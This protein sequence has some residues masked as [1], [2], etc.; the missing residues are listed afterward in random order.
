MNFTHYD[1]GRL[2]KGRTVEVHLQGSVANVYLL[3]QANLKLYRSGMEF[4]AIGGLA[5]SSPVRLQTV[6]AAHWHV[7]ID[8]PNSFGSVKTS[9]R[10]LNKAFPASGEPMKTFKPGGEKKTRPIPVPKPDA[11]PTP[12]VPAPA[13]A[14]APR[15]QTEEK[16]DGYEQVICVQCGILTIKGKFCSECGTPMERACPQCTNV[17]PLGS[18]FC[19][20][21]GFRL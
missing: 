16:Q 18:K 13:P 12:A 20:E 7:A 8:L 5:K 15:P 19:F 6:S 2:D 17:S 3:D 21:C 4:K 9:Y 1:L 11:A 10:V 14:P